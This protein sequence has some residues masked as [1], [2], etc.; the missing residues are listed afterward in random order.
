MAEA[1]ERPYVDFYTKHSIS[2][3]CQDISD[4]KKHCERREYLYRR[5]GIP[6]LLVQGRALLEFGPGS[7]HNAL[8]FHSCNPARYVLVDAN[9]TGLYQC[10]ALF[11]D[12]F[13]SSPYELIESYIE[14]FQTDEKFD[15]VLCEGLIPAQNDPK[16]FTEHVASFVN[17]KG[18]CV[19]TTHDVVSYFSE[20]LRCL[21][22]T[23]LI[24]EEMAFDDQVET[25]V[26]VFGPHLSHLKGMSRSHEDWVIDNIIHKSMWKNSS[27]FSIYEAIDALEDS[28]DVY[29]VSPFFVTDWR[30]YK[31][32]YGERRRFNEVAKECYLKNVHNLL[33]YRHLSESNKIDANQKIME[34]CDTV[35]KLIISYGNDRQLCTLQSIADNL[36]PLEIEIR[37]VFPETADALLDFR[38][39]LSNAAEISTD[40]D[41]GRFAAWWGRGMQYV[42][43]MKN[44]I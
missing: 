44:E 31:D 41:W 18:I 22:G 27:L 32:V 38:Q 28:F 21:I 39:N 8:F 19:I 5:L 14:A 3:V 37:K 43:F 11:K 34:L 20:L 24:K 1:E 12:K 2:P 25:L 35:W 16:L 40:T 17:A 4:F 13:P 9:K 42:S 33:D 6:A 36:K 7:G 23:I 10:E 15:L 26:K 29:G 30:W